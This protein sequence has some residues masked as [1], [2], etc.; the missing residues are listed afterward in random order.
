MKRIVAYMFSAIAVTATVSCEKKVLDIVP[1]DRLSASSAFSTPTK[2]ESAVVGGYNALQ[3]ANFLSGRALIYVDLLGEDIYDRNSYFGDVARFTMLGNNTIPQGVWNAAY[4]SIATANRVIAGIN[5]NPNVISATTATELKA[6]CL[7]VRAISHFYLVNF[8]AQPYGFTADA[9]HPGIPVILQSFSSNDPAANQPRA[10]VAAVYTSII[11]D[12]TTALADLPAT[13]GTTY[14]TKSRATKAAA[15]ALLARVHLY[16]GDY[17]NAKTVSQNIINGNYG[18]FA[19]RPT[20]SGAFGPGN[21]QTAETIWS[22]PNNASDN[23]NTN[24][25]LPQHYARDGR[26]DLP[27]SASFRNVATNT[28]FAIDDL[29]RNMIV[30]G[31][32]GNAALFFTTK[33][34]DVATRADWAPVLRYAEVLLTYAEAAAR[35]ATGIDADALAKLNLVRDRARVSAAQYTAG[36]F[37][38]RDAFVAAILG[39][40]RI[41]LAFEG[42]RFWDL[43]RTRSAVNNKYDSDGT[44]ILPTL[45]YG[46]NKAVFPIP[47][48]EVDKSVGVLVQNQGY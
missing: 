10:T 8:F 14:A 24:N 5:A 41:E 37:A 9:S 18:N 35:T 13:H 47:Q 46:N 17:A 7:F 11:A 40:R 21:Y 30:N 26:A 20:P 1:D 45:A 33:Y 25:A 16:K 19:L 48:V 4:A 39:E 36:S 2:I 44:S 34:P 15:A 12:L 38:N 28:Y 3:S 31:T 32:G 27:V 22:I 42:H 43:M 23:P 29:R 6:E